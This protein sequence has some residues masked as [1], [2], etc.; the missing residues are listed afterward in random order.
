MQK[1][2]MCLLALFAIFA[3]GC[4]TALIDTVTTAAD[5]VAK[6]A[7]KDAR[8][9]RK[10]ERSY[11]RHHD[12]HWSYWY[13]PDRSWYYTDGSHWY[14]SDNNAWKTYKFDRKFGADDFERADYR[15]PAPDVKI[16]VPGHQ[17]YIDR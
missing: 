2:R 11:W 17:I 9:E 10:A 1:V 16:Q 8:A 14:Y 12:G 5:P 13:Q 3:V 6:E 4:T 7:R 15:N